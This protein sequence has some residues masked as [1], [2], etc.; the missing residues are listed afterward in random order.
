MRSLT[1]GIA[2]AGL[3]GRL[4]AWRLSGL[5]HEVTVF[6]PAPG[7]NAT[8][9]AGWTAAGMLSPCAELE[10]ANMAVAALGWR[11]LDLWP[12]W[13]ALLP[14]PVAFARRGSL[15]LAHRSDRGCAQRTL[16]VLQRKLAEVASLSPHQKAVPCPYAAPQALPLNEL[17]TLEPAI[18]GPSH[19]WLLPGEGQIHTVQAMH[20]LAAGASAQGCQWRWGYTVF[21]MA[22]GQ[23]DGH[24]FDWVFDV[25]GVGARSAGQKNAQNPGL[26]V[27][28][29]R[30]EI[31]WLHAPGLVLNRPL[32]L[33]HPRWRVYLVPRPGDIV[34]VGATEIESED[35]SPVS[36]RSLLGLLSAA[37]SVLPELAEARVVH[38]E[39]NLRPALP[40]NLPGLRVE[41]GLTQINGL[42]RHGWLVAPA[43]V[44]DALAHPQFKQTTQ[45]S[46]EEISI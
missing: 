46:T 27:R 35:R 37:H 19:A 16:A 8:G 18:H 12:Q 10:C 15:L 3:L 1:M 32:R 34:V 30:G 38:M 6:D 7:P 44:E 43:L 39:T 23:I 42:F 41:A 11:S 13:L 20:A 25:R 14:E 31:V 33:M 17:Q 9:A 5:G 28:G 29:V 36:V 24:H 21:D 45:T 2:G 26:D 22:P 4:L 40:D